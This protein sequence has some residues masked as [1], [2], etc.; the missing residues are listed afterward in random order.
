MATRAKAKN[1]VPGPAPD[2][3]S[4][5]QRPETRRDAQAHVPDLAAAPT[6]RSD[7]LALQKEFIEAYHVLLERKNAVLT[8]TRSKE[9]R[10]GIAL[11]QADLVTVKCLCIQC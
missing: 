4:P 10:Q 8:T 5:A 7:I 6:T 2:P 11:F 9:R 1:V 3:T